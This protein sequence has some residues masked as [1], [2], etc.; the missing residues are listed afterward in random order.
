MH[1]TAAAA[2][3]DVWVTASWLESFSTEKSS[4]LLYG[5]G[6]MWNSNFN[7]KFALI[8]RVNPTVSCRIS[9]V[10]ISSPHTS[11]ATGQ[12]CSPCNLIAIKYAFDAKYLNKKYISKMC[13][14]QFRRKIYVLH[15]IALPN[16]A[17]LTNRL[18]FHSY[19]ETEK[20]ARHFAA[21]CPYRH[22]R[23]PMAKLYDV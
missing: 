3:N 21:V 1:E 20:I 12:D 15:R 11:P 14:M 17:G 13:K 8:Y 16:S 18:H 9:R 4:S 2:A 6:D 10:T 19:A 22:H 5:G 7:S 23:P